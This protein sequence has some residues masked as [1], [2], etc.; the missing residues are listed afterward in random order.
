MSVTSIDIQNP[1]EPI[2]SEFIKTHQRIDS[3]EEDENIDLFIRWARK[4]V[5]KDASITLVEK[6]VRMGFVEPKDRYYLK[7]DTQETSV[8]NF[9]YIDEDGNTIELTDTELHTDELP[10][11]VIANDVPDSAR[12]IKI[13]YK[14][15]PSEDNPIILAVVERI[16]MLLSYNVKVKKA[17]KESY[18]YLIDT[19]GVK[20]FN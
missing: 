3:V 4:S 18:K 14:A 8:C 17:A 10:N 12:E 13:N 16:I 11:Y 5:E 7:Y 6:D 19:L 1:T 20:Y 15:T 9:S 2:T